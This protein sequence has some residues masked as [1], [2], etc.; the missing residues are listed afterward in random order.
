MLYSRLVRCAVSASLLA[1]SAVAI[2]IAAAPSAAATTAASV[3][4]SFQDLRPARFLDTRTGL[5]AAKA[6]VRGGHSVGIQIT[7]RGLVP[8]SGVSA[9]ALTVTA[10]AA[11]GSG[12]LTVFG[13]GTPRPDTADLHYAPAL[14][15]SNLVIAKVGSGGMVDVYVGGTGTVQLA[16]D[17]SGYYLSGTP[18]LAGTFT[19]LMPQRFL[20][21]REGIGAP[22]A[23]VPAGHTLAVQFAGRGQ[24]P[25]TGVAAVAI[26]LTATGPTTTGSGDVTVYAH[27]TARPATSD[28]HYAH[29]QAAQ[30][31]VVAALGADGRVD[32]SV[33]GTGSAQL[34]GDVSGYFVSGAANR[35]GTFVPLAPHDGS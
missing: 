10:T 25:S 19:P 14:P 27:G 24:V 3:P 8:A 5:G 7:G 16:A 34:V 18:S 30:N 15:E 32:L 6:A 1:G 28:L 13:H 12:Y 11:T 21:T 33:S 20:S 23:A 2:S 35:A 4:G 22:M 17:V 26:E 31:L 29:G 9:V